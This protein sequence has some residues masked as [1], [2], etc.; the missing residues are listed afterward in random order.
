[1]F[2]VI[3]RFGNNLF[4]TARF[5]NHLLKKMFWSCSVRKRLIWKRSCF[6]LLTGERVTG[7]K[8]CLFNIGSFVYNGGGGLSQQFSKSANL[9]PAV[10][11]LGDGCFQN[12][13]FVNGHVWNADFWNDLSV[14]EPL[15]LVGYTDILQCR[16]LCKGGSMFRFMVQCNTF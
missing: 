11:V 10:L 12:E 5:G 9:R 8:I 3:G 1:M 7:A 16:L 6:E 4:I 2:L 15:K 14:I 13:L